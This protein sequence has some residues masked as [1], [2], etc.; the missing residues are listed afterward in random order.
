MTDDHGERIDHRETMGEHL[1]D[2]VNLDNW[3]KASNK[4]EVDQN[5]FNHFSTWR[6]GLA[7]VIRQT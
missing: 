2:A 4:S 5:K 1:A 6:Y 3:N 7:P